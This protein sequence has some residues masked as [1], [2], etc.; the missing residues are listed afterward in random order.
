MKLTRRFKQNLKLA[1]L[2]AVGL[3][4]PTFS[5]FLFGLGK[6]VIGIMILLILVT[7][8]NA[9]TAKNQ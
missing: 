5:T 1:G 3:G 2:F 4:I 9:L 6:T 8:I 7:L